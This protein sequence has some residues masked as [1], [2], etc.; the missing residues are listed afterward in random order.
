MS[1]YEHRNHHVSLEDPL[2]ERWAAL[3]EE[4]W[5]QPAAK[6]LV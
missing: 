5:F 6:Y 1:W 4:D 3:D 2:H